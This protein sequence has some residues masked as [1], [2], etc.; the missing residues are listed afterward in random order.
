MISL[1]TAQ[2]LKAAGLK[3]EPQV[4]DW[5]YNHHGFVSPVSLDLVAEEHVPKINEIVADYPNRTVE[6]AP[7]LDQLLTEIEGSGYVW[8]SNT[9]WEK[10]ESGEY[11]I[12]GYAFYIKNCT[13]NF[14]GFETDTPAEAAAQ[15]RL[16]ILEGVNQHGPQED[17]RPETAD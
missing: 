9:I 16:W 12:K 1:E 13:M 5:F 4:G 14:K 3:W 2:K 11:V 17:Q 7:R 15:A 8:E 6:F 10:I